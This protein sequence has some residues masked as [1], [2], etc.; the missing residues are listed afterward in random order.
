METDLDSRNVYAARGGQHLAFVSGPVS[1]YKAANNA[2]AT[3]QRPSAPSLSHRSRSRRRSRCRRRSK[4]FGSTVSHRDLAPSR[5]SRSHLT[6]ARVHCVLGYRVV[7]LRY[8]RAVLLV[9]HAQI[10]T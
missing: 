6:R 8:V 7:R 3:T 2:G 5:C 1:R 4:T 9:P 10:L